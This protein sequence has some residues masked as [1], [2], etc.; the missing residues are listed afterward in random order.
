MA[1]PPVGG[2]VGRGDRRRPDADAA[3]SGGP[4]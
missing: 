1:L 4:P 3:R 2:P